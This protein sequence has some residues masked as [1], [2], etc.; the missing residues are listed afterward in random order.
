MPRNPRPATSMMETLIEYCTTG[1]L[2]EVKLNLTMADAIIR[3]REKM[4]LKDGP[5]LPLRPARPAAAPPATS[6]PVAP[7]AAAA[8]TAPRRRRGPNKPRPPVPAETATQ[9]APPA[10]AASTAPLPEGDGEPMGEE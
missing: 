10:A 7:P 8:P 9:A 2:G 6:M 1:P 3:G 4:G 5:A